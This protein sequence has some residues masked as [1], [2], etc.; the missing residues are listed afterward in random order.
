M[1]A[2]P[3]NPYVRQASWIRTIISAFIKPID[4]KKS[5]GGL[6]GE[7]V[8]AKE[9]VVPWTRAQ[10]AAFLICTGG[11]LYSNLQKGQYQW[12][13]VLRKEINADWVDTAND[14]AM[15]GKKTLLNS[16]Q[17]IRALWLAVNDIFTCKIHEWRLLEWEPCEDVGDVTEDAVTNEIRSLHGNHIFPMLAD[18]ADCLAS[19]DWRSS[20]ADELSEEERLIRKGFRGSGGYVELKKKLLEH[21]AHNSGSGEVVDAADTALRY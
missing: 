10:Q 14:P 16:D 7:V 15:F 20:A 9:N 12:A 8:N 1:L 5:K 6:F 13:N 11:E 19:F 2:T 3:N 18:L 21:I 4:L 17:G